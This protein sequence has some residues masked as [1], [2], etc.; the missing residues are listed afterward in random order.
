MSLVV[1]VFHPYSRLMG[2]RP[3]CPH[4]SLRLISVECLGLGLWYTPFEGHDLCAS[5][6]RLC[7]VLPDLA[8]FLSIIVHILCY[9]MLT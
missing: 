5:V 3:I 4:S 7:R 9:L 6:A 1:N 8:I 2:D